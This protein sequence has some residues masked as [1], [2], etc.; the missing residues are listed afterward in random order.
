MSVILHIPCED[1]KLG[2]VEITRS[3][4]MIFLD[5]EIEYDIAYEA[6]GGRP[7]FCSQAL[8]QWLDHPMGFICGSGLVP[9]HHLGVVACGLVRQAIPIIDAAIAPETKSC[10]KYALGLASVCEK[11]FIKPRRDI[12]RVYHWKQDLTRAWNSRVSGARRY[13]EMPLFGEDMLVD[14]ALACSVMV[15]DYWD[16]VEQHRGWHRP[17]GN[18]GAIAEYVRDAITWVLYDQSYHHPEGF[19]GLMKQPPPDLVEKLNEVSRM[20]AVWAVEILEK[21]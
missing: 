1:G 10:L 2:R 13:G 14:A 9:V 17:P 4:D 12:S 19:R 16:H 21:L 15:M 18:P 11:Q 5:H 20:E 6:M 8:Q 7:S 3:L